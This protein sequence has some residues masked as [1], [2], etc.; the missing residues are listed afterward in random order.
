ML[1]VLVHRR[2][3][4]IFC[5]WVPSIST[6]SQVLASGYSWQDQ[7]TRQRL[8][9][10]KGIGPVT[11]N[12]GFTVTQLG[13]HEDD[14]VHQSVSLT[15]EVSEL[16]RATPSLVMPNLL[17]GS[18]SLTHCS[19][20]GCNRPGLGL[21]AQGLY[22]VWLHKIF[23]CSHIDILASKKSSVCLINNDIQ[24]LNKHPEKWTMK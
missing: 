14:P 10:E 7:A 1:L 19:G 11:Y 8:H 3:V 18:S 13:F 21:T 9:H 12:S 16:T 2:S 17:G 20:S 6:G 22:S 15:L 23:R 5:F 4:F 24:R